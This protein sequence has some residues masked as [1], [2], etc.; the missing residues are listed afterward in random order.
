MHYFTLLTLI[1][2][3]EINLNKHYTEGAKLIQVTTYTCIWI[4]EPL[5]TAN[6]EVLTSVH[7]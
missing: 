2:Y 7:S 1:K 4:L 3:W 6:Y 5:D